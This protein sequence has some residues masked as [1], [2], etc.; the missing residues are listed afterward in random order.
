LIGTHGSVDDNELGRD[1]ASLGQEP[2]TLRLLEMPVE[3][4]SEHTLE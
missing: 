4:A 2:L 3:V 1:A